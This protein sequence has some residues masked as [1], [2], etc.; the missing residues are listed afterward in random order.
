MKRKEE[1]ENRKKNNLDK[2]E[3]VELEFCLK[4]FKPIFQQGN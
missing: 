2:G 1:I 3:N 4:L